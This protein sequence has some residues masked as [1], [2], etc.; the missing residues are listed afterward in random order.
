MLP[1]INQSTGEIEMAAL[2]QRAAAR[3][4]EQHGGTNYPAWCLRDS[5]EWLKARAEAERREWRRDRGLPDDTVVV[6]V[7]LP[8]WGASGDGFG[9]Q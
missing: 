4:E 3:A 1:L 8:E 9:A 6:L 2:V 5:L 7:N